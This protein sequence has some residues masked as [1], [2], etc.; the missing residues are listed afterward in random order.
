MGSEE[1]KDKGIEPVGDNKSRKQNNGGPKGP[2]K[3]PSKKILMWLLII[4]AFVLALRSVETF[5]SEKEMMLTY[6]QFKALL[7]HTGEPGQEAEQV[8][9][10]EQKSGAVEIVDV[11][12]EQKGINNA[13]LRGEVAD[14]SHLSV[15]PS[16]E[17][18]AE[19]K[20][21]VVNLPFVDSDMLR[22]WDEYGIPY[23]FEQDRAWG[24]IV[25]SIL[26]YGLL[27]LIYIFFIRNMHGG[28]GQKGM[29]SFG[30][31]KAKVHSL[32][33]PQIT[34][35]DAAGVEEAKGELA[36]IIEFLKDP[37]KFKKLGGKIP[38]GVLLL[39]PPGTGK[40]LLA[41]CVA[42]EA[43]VPF[44]SMSGSDFVEMFVGVGASRVRDLFETAKRSSPCIVFIDE[45][46]AVGRQRGAGLGGGH[47][48]REQ[49]LNQMLVEMDGFEVNSG[50]ILIAATN[51]PDVLDPALLR[52]GRFD[53]QVVVDMPDVKG[54]EGILKVHTKN[55]PLAPDV[56]LH[57]IARGTPGFVGAD[58]S[59]LVNEAALMAAR[60]GQECVTMLDFEEAKDKVVMGTERKSMVLSEKEK[61]TTAYHEA[62]HAICNI[63]CK[64]ADP[65]HKVTIIPRGRA[66]GVTYSLPGED[67]HSYTK[68]YILD[69]VCIMLG[70]R[71]AE[72]MV[73]NHQ[74]TGAS[75]DIKQATSLIRK[76]ICDYGMTNEL[77]PLS[78]GEKDDSIFLG[79]DMNRHRDFSDKTAE[80]IDRVMRS[81]I[82][83]Q[84]ERA[85]AILTEHRDQLEWL[86]KALLE[87]EM[88]DREEIMKVIK[89]DTLES[90]KKS[91]VLPR[92][93]K[94]DKPG[95]TITPEI[96]PVAEEQSLNS[97]SE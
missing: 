57:T 32:D 46:D 20:H 73:F 49:T 58:L 13:V 54:R 48:E 87:H 39:G 6:S 78:Y 71:M 72:Q 29:F 14:P 27:I 52:P 53:R 37:K 92:T 62:G 74:T 31:S 77:G 25:L 17:E 12:V 63:H 90:A 24:S 79:R 75:N 91:R 19:T 59:N 88:L 16:L 21:F 9:S 56:D 1:K 4:V 47:D 89:G 42:G 8:E 3:D 85:K 33:R 36:E 97:D 80:E 23:T 2:R 22:E 70:G 96:T 82:E 66:L 55:T 86:A 95:V 40:T 60:F 67:K 61:Q 38:K 7:S 28:G 76:M 45:I 84:L 11:V 15:I 26:P 34:F 83:E 43:G 10:E 64:D 44:L 30:K 51:R 5:N 68:Q 41:R 93:L 94:K 50:I 69:R 65:L 81:V 35:A 18:P